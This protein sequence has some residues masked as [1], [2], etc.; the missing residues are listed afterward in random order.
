MARIKQLS[1]SKYFSSIIISAILLLSSCS[2]QEETNSNS[3]TPNVPQSNQVET[4]NIE[5]TQKSV[6]DN[7]VSVKIPTAFH[8]MSE[9][10]IRAKY[11]SGRRPSIVYSNETGS[12]N[13]AFNH[14]ST[15]LTQSRLQM[16]MEGIVSSI[17]NAGTAT[18]IQKEIVKTGNRDFIVLEFTIPSGAERIYNLMY[19]TDIDG[20]MAIGTFNCTEKEMAEWKTSARTIMTSIKVKS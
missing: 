10:D 13:V 8:E 7:N 16:T 4:S 14:T 5:L 1:I 18:W 3:A 12:V 11:P 17:S 20:K 15:P 2:N 6:L 9:E 19:I